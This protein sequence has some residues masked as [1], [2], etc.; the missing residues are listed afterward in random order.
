MF[1]DICKL[2]TT[3]TSFRDSIA[4]LQLITDFRDSRLVAF[5][6]GE[7][8][9]TSRILC[10]L[11]GGYFTYASIEPGKE[12]AQGQIPVRDLIEIYEM[13]KE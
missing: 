4:T 1:A 2:V 7:P 13:V 5:A 6:M 3:A 10:P 9:I 11:V 8:G 12:S